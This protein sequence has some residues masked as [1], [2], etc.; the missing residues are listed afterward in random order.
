MPTQRSR[1]RARIDATE[2]VRTQW[3]D[4]LGRTPAE[5]VYEDAVAEPAIVRDLVAGI[6]DAATTA[7]GRAG[8]NG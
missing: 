6:I 1:L 4:A 8:A 3:F 7:G 2:T 5:L